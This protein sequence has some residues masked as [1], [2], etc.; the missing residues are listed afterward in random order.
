MKSSKKL[1]EYLRVGNPGIYILITF[2]VIVVLSVII[3]AFTGVLSLTE[4]ITGIVLS[5]ETAPVP[6]VSVMCSVNAPAFNDVELVGASAS[7]RMADGRVFPGT[8]VSCPKT[9][10]TATDYTSEIKLSDLPEHCI[11]W[12]RMQVVDGIYVYPVTITSEADL[13]EYDFQLANVSIVTGQLHPIAY[14]MQ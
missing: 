3:W 8:V 2:L 10:V 7:I 9:P 11:D 14:L 12:I 1:I 13:S 4:E 5:D 6:T